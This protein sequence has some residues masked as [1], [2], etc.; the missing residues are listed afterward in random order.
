MGNLPRATD[1]VP[2]REWLVAIRMRQFGDVL[3]AL[4]ALRAMKA[5]RPA[6]G[7][8]YVAGESFHPV[9]RGLDFIDMLLPEPPRLDKGRGAVAYS[10]YIADIRRLRP[11]AVIDFHGSAR[12][13]LLTLLSGAPVRVGFKVRGRRHA[14]TVV[15]PRGVFM[16]GRY[17]PRSSLASGFSLVRHVGADPIAA[18]PPEVPVDS[19]I[20]T[21]ATEALAAVGV[22]RSAL[23]ARRVVGIN[24]GRPYPAKEWP[25]DRFVRLAACLR[26]AGWEVLVMWG[27]GEEDTAR[28]IAREAGAGVTLAPAF[29]L[30]TLMGALKCLS[31]LVTIDSG[32]KHLAVCNR[33]PTLSLFG[34]TD[35]REWH[36]GASHD[37]YLWKGLSCSPCRRLTCPFGSPCMDFGPEDVMSLF[38]D[39]M[40]EGT[41]A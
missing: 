21:R 5:H 33:I 35:P 17:V 27:P 3:A 28:M 31:V 26:E 24:P 2:D 34:A 37:R 41:T 20:I 6:R 30:V 1:F 40:R 9:L 22:S 19:A 38:E 18:V 8:A 39:M 16:D 29:D 11:A 36:I 14:Y 25:R 32:L 12:S 4:E 13:A 15:E 23:D 10:R 7:I